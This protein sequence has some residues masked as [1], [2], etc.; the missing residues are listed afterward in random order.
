MK[1]YLFHHP[2]III[3]NPNSVII[4]SK[5]KSFGNCR[6]LLISFSFLPISI[7]MQRYYF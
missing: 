2:L 7:L 3:K 5:V 4:S 1:I 6:N